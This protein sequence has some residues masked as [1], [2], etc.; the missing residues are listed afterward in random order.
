MLQLYLVPRGR[1][2]VGDEVFDDIADEV[3]FL[4]VQFA[5][6]QNSG[7]LVC[8]ER[9]KGTR[10]WSSKINQKALNVPG[11]LIQLSSSI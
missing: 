4:F 9:A 7:L 11:L 2:Y 3:A 6:E 1:R 8:E 10:T 5:K